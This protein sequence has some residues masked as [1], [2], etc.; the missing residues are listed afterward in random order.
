MAFALLA[1][2]LIGGALLVF[3]QICTIE[4]TR[5]ILSHPAMA[6]FNFSILAA[7][8]ILIDFYGRPVYSWLLQG[9][10][11]DIKP[12]LR[13]LP[14]IYWGIFFLALIPKPFLATYILSSS[15]VSPDPYLPGKL[16]LVALTVTVLVGL[17]VFYLLLNLIGRLVEKLDLT[18]PI[19][20]IA[21]RIILVGTLSPIMVGTIFVLYHTAETGH[22]DYQ[23]L[24]LMGLLTIM[25]A[26]GSSLVA[27]SFKRSLRPLSR[28]F[29]SSRS[30]TEYPLEEIRALSSDEI[31]VLTHAYQ[32]LRKQ[33]LESRKILHGTENKFRELLDDIPDIIYRLNAE[34]QITF[35]SDNVEQVFAYKPEELI[36]TYM[37]EHYV[38]PGER[39]NML[40]SL[41]E[42][43]GVLKEY[44][45]ALR[46]KSGSTVLMEI[47]CHFVTSDAGVVT[48]I[49]GVAKDIT[50]LV[51]NQKQLTLE[52]QR[53]VSTL[54]SITDSVISADVN[55]CVDYANP[56]A[57]KLFGSDTLYPGVD[58]RDILSTLSDEQDLQ[59][60]EQIDKILENQVTQIT[61][62][63]KM[64]ASKNQEHTLK[65]TLSSLLSENGQVAGL[66][67]VIHDLSEL[68]EMTRELFHQARHDELTGL[69]NRTALYDLLEKTLL[70][71]PRSGETSSLGFIDLENF[72]LVNDSIGHQAGDELLT[73]IS[74]MMQKTIAGR[75]H[76]AR[77][78]GDEFALL[79]YGEEEQ[80]HQ[81]FKELMASINNFRFSW[82]D[83][84]YMIGANIGVVTIGKEMESVSRLMAE[85]DH[86]C[87]LAKKQGKNHIVL[88][89]SG[90]MKT[91]SAMR[92]MDWANRISDALEKGHF[93]LMCQAI[94]GTDET[95]R[96]NLSRYEI[97]LQLNEPEKE[98]VAA[99]MFLPAVENYGFVRDLDHYV[100]SATI[101]E[102][103]HL[104]SEKSQLEFSL[105]LS[106]QTLIEDGFENHLLQKFK[107]AG[108]SPE[109]LLIEIRENTYH[110][111]YTAL[112]GLVKRLAEYGFRFCLD[113]MGGQDSTFMFLRNIPADYLKITGPLVRNM[114]SNETD[115]IMVKSL[116]QTGKA[117]DMKVMADWVEE[118]ALLK[119]LNDIGVD[120][121]QGYY[122]HKPEP[123]SAVISQLRSAT[124]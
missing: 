118:E 82:N 81:L 51:E 68:F 47:N 103:S 18:R 45:I 108:L 41:K 54:E 89:K 14:Y 42:N 80:V 62:M 72:K 56:V 44:P 115:R 73:A 16:S 78:G 79:T 84:S 49:E 96:D 22:L 36:G 117:L 122:I 38:D 100:L 34:G 15:G 104:G 90:N 57:K 114:L 4:Q 86:A 95:S 66:T 98:P 12:K 32:T 119:M 3:L 21:P 20:G 107:N 30:I 70:N 28:A 102:L 77:I 6:G 113:N 76:L 97:L 61:T 7:G 106:T 48:G 43:Q 64:A 50:T 60:S 17:P 40:S 116:C 58:I 53:T 24:S 19:V 111:G 26:I 121:I 23:T 94:V 92:M 5:L 75:G 25:V 29:E 83:R 93:R 99:N 123:F 71:L 88:Q 55:G 13:L 112:N 33:Y 37:H 63:V 109:Q 105:N 110:S 8:L 67:V 10:D 52:K 11:T 59:A 2:M 65:L 31:G 91:R 74:V 85:V 46:N 9:S 69:L 39:Q 35:I 87:S 124:G 120:Y 27:Y 1:P 101:N